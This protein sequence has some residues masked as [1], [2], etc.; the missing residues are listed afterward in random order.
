MSANCE[1]RLLNLI[2]SGAFLP[3]PANG[4]T[5]GSRTPLRT[6]HP[7]HPVSGERPKPVADAAKQADSF[8]PVSSRASGNE[9]FYTKAIWGPVADSGLPRRG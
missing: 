2:S 5:A 3:S 4:C 9:V 8:N 7:R 6:Q 1:D